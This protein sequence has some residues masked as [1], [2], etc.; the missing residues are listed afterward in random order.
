MTIHPGIIGI[1]ISK[2][3]FDIFDAATGRPERLTNSGEAAR[4]I[5]ARLGA[6]ENGF[7]I[8]EATGQ[9]DR[10]LRTALDAAGIAYARVNPSRARDFAKAAG[11]LAKTDAV[12]ARMLA[13]MG[14]ALA[15]KP[16]ICYSAA[17]EA[18]AGLHKRRDQL[19]GVRAAEKAR[20][21]ETGDASGSL[22]AHIGWLDAEIARLDGLIADAVAGDAE[23]NAK[24][25]LLRSVPGVGPVTAATLMALMPELGRLDPKAI[26]ALAGL[27]PFNADSGQFRG[28][29]RIAGGRRRVRNALYMAALVASRSSSHFKRLYQNLRDK[30][31]PAKLALVAIAR[32]LIVTLNAMMRD[33]QP[34]RA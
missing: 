11:F 24:D 7:A 17:S 18:L 1:D 31:K 30:G 22:E 6:R 23:L 25:K 9:Y 2:H 4:L 27:A 13:A 34:F 28:V 3:H 32:K 12:D 33:N 21:S 15:P 5:A 16:T 26:A 20:L 29:R 8:F 10:Y 14:Q 19:V